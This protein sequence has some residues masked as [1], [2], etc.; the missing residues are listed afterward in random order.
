MIFYLSEMDF[1]EKPII[2]RY[3]ESVKIFLKI[4]FFILSKLAHEMTR[5]IFTYEL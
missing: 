4:L 3:N 5:T 2:N 1:V